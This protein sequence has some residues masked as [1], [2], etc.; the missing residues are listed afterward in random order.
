MQHEWVSISEY[1][2]RF[3]LSEITVRR[4]IKQ[5]RINAELKNG[6]YFISSPPL[7][8]IAKA[9][10]LS[11]PAVASA[12]TPPPPPVKNSSAINELAEICKSYLAELKSKEALT[13]KNHNAEIEI[14]KIQ[15]EK[16]EH[17]IVALKQQIDDL[18]L[19]IKMLD[20]KL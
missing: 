7:E 5:G 18:Q 2:R 19:L 12:S 11:S 20:N 13:Q 9:E 10:T 3:N 15:I 4:R 8:N 17:E 16:L 1:A 6:K 14:Y